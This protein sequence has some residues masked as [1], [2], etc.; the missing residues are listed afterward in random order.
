MLR[1]EH[2][3]FGMFF[4]SR[5]TYCIRESLNFKMF[6][7]VLDQTCQQNTSCIYSNTLPGLDYNLATCSEAY[8]IPPLEVYEKVVFTNAYYGGNEPKGSRIV[9]VN[10]KKF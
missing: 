8:N 4:F 9:F 10:G 2:N 1:R 5:K 3:F 7:F 6:Y